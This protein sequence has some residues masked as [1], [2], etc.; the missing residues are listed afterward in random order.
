M[1]KITSVSIPCGSFVGVKDNKASQL[2]FSVFPNP[3]AG[4]FSVLLNADLAGEYTVNVIDVTGRI[5]ET[6]AVKAKQGNNYVS[7]ANKV[8]PAGAYAVEISSA[9]SKTVKK[10]IVQ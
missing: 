9:S 4:T 10:L 2:D 1:T 5:V 6:Q 3:S 7:F 8:L